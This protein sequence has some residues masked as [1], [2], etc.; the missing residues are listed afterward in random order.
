MKLLSF[1]QNGKTHTGALTDMGVVDLTVLGFPDNMNGIIAGGEEMKNQIAHKIADTSLPVLDMASLECANVTSPQKIICVGLNYRKHAEETG[2]TAPDHI[3]FFSKFNDAL[4]PSGQSVTLPPWQ[5]NYDYEAELVIVMGKT[6][7]NVPKDKA[8][9]Y[10]FGY[11]CGNDLSARDSQ[12]LTSQW[13]A[14][15][16]FPG[17]GPAGPVIVTA[18]CFDPNADN[19]ITCEVNGVQVQSSV[20]SDMIFDCADIVSTAS[21]YFG[22]GAGDLIFTGT[23][24][25]VIIGKEKDKRVWLKPGDTVKVTIDGI[26]ALATPLV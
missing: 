14:G 3:I 2:G 26:G 12:F 1:I 19:G 4:T 11:T 17:F 10:V 22:L 21:R 13:L 7:R 20:T 5:K 23:P 6:A 8:L 18:D 16:A 25:G 9:E 15:K 24:S